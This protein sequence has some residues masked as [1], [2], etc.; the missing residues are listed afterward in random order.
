MKSQCLSSSNLSLEFLYLHYSFVFK[1]RFT[2]LYRHTA[3]IEK[4]VPKIV[5]QNGY[6][7]Y[8]EHIWSE[9]MY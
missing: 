8:S 2:W 3:E 7:N 6:D 9:Y 5:I 4:Y 1:C